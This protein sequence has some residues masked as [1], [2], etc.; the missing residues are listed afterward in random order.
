MTS[1]NVVQPGASAA[2]GYGSSPGG[3]HEPANL[4]DILERVLDKGL[5][6]A[7][8]IQVNLLD[9]ELLTI[10]LRLVI[11]S[12]QTARELGIDWWENDPWLNANSSDRHQLEEE[13]RKLRGRV[14][15]LEGNGDSARQDK[16]G[17]RRRRGSR[18]G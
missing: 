15:A 5:V 3:G 12:V 9:I 18:H 6:I 17:D 8:D 7:G 1:E 2:Q 16:E 4:G 11:A 14:A 10:K 13:N